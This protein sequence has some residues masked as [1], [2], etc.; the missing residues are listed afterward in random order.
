M[1]SGTGGAR[2]RPVDG[3]ADPGLPRSATSDGGGCASGRGWN[4]GRGVRVRLFPRLPSCVILLQALWLLAA[5]PCHAAD[6]PPRWEGAAFE[7]DPATFDGSAL[8][9][10]W[11]VL[12]DATDLRVGGDEEA[13]PARIPADIL[14]AD[15]AT[16]R[17]LAPERPGAYRLFITIRDRNGKAATANLPFLVR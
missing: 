10:E 14:H 8:S 17:F 7:G 1:Y 16:V 6:P 13:A 9:T 4:G 5:S 11:K 3:A 12:A 15:A 2:G